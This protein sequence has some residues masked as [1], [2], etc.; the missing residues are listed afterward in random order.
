[1]SDWVK[2]LAE[3]NDL[4]EESTGFI[5]TPIV[6][7]YKKLKEMIE[8]GNVYGC[9][10]QFKDIYEIALK[11][12]VVSALI[13]LDDKDEDALLNNKI[14]MEKMLLSPLAMG[15]WYEL[16][17]SIINAD[18]RKKVSLPLTIKNILEKTKVLYNKKVSQDYSN[19]TNWRNDTIGHGMLRNEDREEYKTEYNTLL[20]N[21]KD[22]FSDINDEYKNLY[23][24]ID[25][26]IF[27]D[28]MDDERLKI[29]FEGDFA[30]K[31]TTC[32][33]D[34]SY[35]EVKRFLSKGLF[36][37]SFYL[38]KNKIKYV[39]YFFGLYDTE[40]IGVFQKYIDTL[41]DKYKDRTI[42]ADYVLKSE[43]ELYSYLNTPEKYI[44]PDGLGERINCFFE[45]HNKGIISL[46]MEQGM[47][48]T[49]FSNSITG[50]HEIDESTLI[51]DSIV[52]TYNISAVN[53]RGIND[54]FEYINF[55]F[56]NV[57]DDEYRASNKT[58]PRISLKDDNPARNMAFFLNSYKKIY[59]F[60]YDV[61]RLVLVIDGVDE[62]TDETSILTDWMIGKEFNYLLDDGIYV[63]YTTRFPDEK[64]ISK[65][66]SLIIQKMIDKSD[67]CIQI[68]KTD[69][70][71]VTVLKDYISN[72]SKNGD[73][74]SDEELMSILK[75]SDYRFLYLKIF[76]GFELYRNEKPIY[77]EK[78]ICEYLAKIFEKYNTTNQKIAIEFLTCL[79]IFNNIT[80]RDYFEHISIDELSYRFIGVLNDL[81][82]LLSI[83]GDEKGRTYRFANES[84]SKY[85]LEN[86]KND[87]IIMGKRLEDT[88]GLLSEDVI[89][90][91][92][93]DGSNR[94]LKIAIRI[95]SVIVF[96]KNNYGLL[97]TENFL[98]SVMDFRVKALIICE[99]FNTYHADVFTSLTSVIVMLFYNLFDGEVPAIRCLNRYEFVNNHSLLKGMYYENPDEFKNFLEKYLDSNDKIFSDWIY[100]LMQK[101]DDLVDSNFEKVYLESVVKIIDRADNLGLLP[102]LVSYLKP[103]SISDNHIDTLM[104]SQD[105]SRYKCTYSK[106]LE[107]ICKK[108]LDHENMEL[109]L[110]YLASSYALNETYND[111]GDNCFSLSDSQAY[112]VF[113]KME[114]DGFETRLE[115]LNLNDVGFVIKSKVG[116]IGYESTAFEALN[117]SS[118]IRD[119]MRS[120]KEE[121]N[122]HAIASGEDWIDHMLQRTLELFKLERDNNFFRRN[123]L[124]LS[125]GGGVH[126]IREYLEFIIDKIEEGALDVK[127]F[128]LP[129]NDDDTL[130]FLEYI[131]PAYAEI[132][133]YTPEKLLRWIRIIDSA[134]S[135]CK[136]PLYYLLNFEY[137]REID[138]DKNSLEKYLYNYD[139]K[140]QL[141]YITN[142]PMTKEEHLEIKGRLFAS[143]RAIQIMRR[144]FQI[145]D[146]E[147][148]RNIFKDIIAGEKWIFENL[149]YKF[150]VLSSVSIRLMDS[151]M[152][153]LNCCESIGF[154]EDLT[155]REQLNHD[156][157]SFACELKLSIMNY[158]GDKIY[159]P[160]DIIWGINSLNALKKNHKD[161]IDDIDVLLAELKKC[162]F[163]IKNK[164]LNNI[165]NDIEKIC[166]ALNC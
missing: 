148:A 149:Q 155:I 116:S 123:S 98:E 140:I 70:I 131:G 31:I 154:S 135:E 93:S 20:K 112:K 108:E 7:N 40:D 111:M 91:I 156:L 165:E 30:K 52:H 88:F 14:I 34:G 157:S 5:P 113:K 23:F 13:Y 83:Y 24:E 54:F 8:N 37:D 25:G 158:R 29:I 96:L 118:I 68:Y 124:S 105:K 86:Y 95:L 137:G 115:E 80:I 160:Q 12:P 18:K 127:Y 19:I 159:G 48:K 110:T 39:D 129:Y 84:Y 122:I 94:K 28:S 10:L 146:I 104:N 11:I 73:K 41:D 77:G 99:S 109:A 107:I 114:K 120:L 79:S 136:T 71:N 2:K 61:S 45:C 85:I 138:I 130:S 44:V 1:M 50:L 103:F 33:V 141:E 58:L 57:K 92:L 97:L 163:E 102:P 128:N 21:L 87:L 60:E 15:G 75:E 47:G 36:F 17:C 150:D 66:N 64:S 49:A 119:E 76:L 125:V 145:E 4:W 142:K 78:V 134:G 144:C 74:L 62:L 100:F 55:T 164:G 143:R 27:C 59:D 132:C 126:I 3:D 90:E 89:K 35:I 151:R 42:K 139:S 117:E 43:D 53:I 46:C 22:Y 106:I 152:T 63:I 101:D 6:Y 51:S 162:V 32:F 26:E 16:A 67:E 69:P 161:F 133:D 147:A 82:P 9:L 65:N 166:V 153:F 56:A 121:D 81:S 38:R 72:N